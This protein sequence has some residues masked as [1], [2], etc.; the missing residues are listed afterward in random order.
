[1][2]N[3]KWDDRFIELAKH[4]A[5]WSKDPSS[6]VG[7]VLVNNKR[8]VVGMGYNGFPRGTSDDPA[9]YNDRPIKYLRVVHAEVNAVLNATG[10]TDGATA[11]VTHPCCAQCMALL[12]QSGVKRIVWQK[13]D[14]G[15]AERLAD[16]FIEAGAM[17]IEAGVTIEEKS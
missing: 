14:A 11:Y 16:S 7:A 10:N 15:I 3:S 2:R 5:G 1:M 12:I 8:Q 4:V 17:A 9:L 6:Q 13:A